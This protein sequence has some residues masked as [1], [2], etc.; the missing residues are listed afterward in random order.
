MPDFQVFGN[1]SELN[2]TTIFHTNYFAVVLLK[3]Y[4]KFWKMSNMYVS[5]I[6]IISKF[7]INVNYFH[8]GS[9]HLRV[10]NFDC[11]TN[12]TPFIIKIQ[13]EILRKNGCFILLWLFL[14]VTGNL[15]HILFLLQ[16]FYNHRKQI[17]FWLNEQNF[18]F[19]THFTFDWVIFSP[20]CLCT[21]TKMMSLFMRDS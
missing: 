19:S 16:L 11:L 4:N 7:H 12:F 18:F 13:R 6:A 14:K 5:K 2:E 17:G 9:W 1:Q 15:C 21:S 3:K 10:D 20:A 8:S